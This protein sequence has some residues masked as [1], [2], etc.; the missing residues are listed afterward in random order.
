MRVDILL[1]PPE[2][3]FCSIVCLAWKRQPYGS[4]LFG[5]EACIQA[6]TFVLLHR[7]GAVLFV[8]AREKELGTYRLVWL[9]PV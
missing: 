2:V 5:V 4:A 7:F 9:K 8:I 3:E 1:A 6:L